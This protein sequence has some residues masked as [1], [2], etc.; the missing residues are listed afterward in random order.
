V[1]IYCKSQISS[2]STHSKIRAN[3]AK[4]KVDLVY[5]GLHRFIPSPNSVHCHS[6]LLCHG[7]VRYEI[8]NT[9]GGIDAVAEERPDVQ[10]E[11]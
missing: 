3:N 2:L 11:H 5:T 10:R 1:Q 6:F 7:G 9:H 4:L 8:D